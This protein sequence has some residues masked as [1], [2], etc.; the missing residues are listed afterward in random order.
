MLVEFLFGENA[1]V[2]HQEVDFGHERLSVDQARCV[3]PEYQLELLGVSP[4]HVANVLG[5]EKSDVTLLY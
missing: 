5:R 4:F 3:L 2:P 1:K